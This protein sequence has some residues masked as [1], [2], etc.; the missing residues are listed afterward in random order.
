MTD[1][2]YIAWRYI[3]YHKV[4]TTIL[5]VSI[6]FI[7]FLPLALRVLVSLV[8]LATAAALSAGI[9]HIVERPVS[10]IEALAERLPEPTPPT[11][12]TPAQQPADPTESN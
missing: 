3:T 9:V 12:R 8:G 7:L 11:V 6:T 2:L 1:T 10:P 4:K 5:L